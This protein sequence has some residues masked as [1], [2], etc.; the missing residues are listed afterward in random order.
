MHRDIDKTRAYF[1]CHSFLYPYTK[2]IYPCPSRRAFHI[3]SSLINTLL[4]QQAKKL[5]FVVHGLQSIL[6]FFLLYSFGDYF[7]MRCCWVFQNTE[8]LTFPRENNS[9]W[10]QTVIWHKIDY[11]RPPHR[12]TFSTTTATRPTR[13]LACIWTRHRAC[14]RLFFDSHFFSYCHQ[15]NCITQLFSYIL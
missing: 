8:T 3:F 15:P 10:W 4:E 5:L 2:N 13:R 12:N 7:S 11:Q 14:N 1:A 6:F 9:R